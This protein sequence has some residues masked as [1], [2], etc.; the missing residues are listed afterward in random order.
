MRP[1]DQWWITGLV[2]SRRRLESAGASV[3]GGGAATILLRR[4]PPFRRGGRRAAPAEAAAATVPRHPPPAHPPPAGPRR[5]A[6]RRLS[7]GAAPVVRPPARPGAVAGRGGGMRRGRTP[8]AASRCPLT[9]LW[10]TWA[11][12]RADGAVGGGGGEAPARVRR[13]LFEGQ[14]SPRGRPYVTNNASH[15]TRARRAIDT[16]PTSGSCASSLLELTAFILAFL[17][18]AALPATPP[19]PPPWTPRPPWRLRRRWPSSPP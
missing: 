12:A 13:V 6:D 17:V 10:R 4:P 18:V 16:D 8:R 11:P 1:H 9:G 19:A 14:P 5:A 7:C 2:V 3:G 15:P